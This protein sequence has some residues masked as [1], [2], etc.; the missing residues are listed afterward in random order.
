MRL[1]LQFAVFRHV[2]GGLKGAGQHFAFCMVY[3]TFDAMIF[4]ALPK[5]FL[6]IESSRLCLAIGETQNPFAPD[7]CEW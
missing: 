5:S 2:S 1:D 4:R 3:L 7:F 6:R